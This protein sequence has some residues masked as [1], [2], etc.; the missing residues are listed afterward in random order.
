MLRIWS[1]L[2]GLDPKLERPSKRYGSVPTDG[3]AE[4][5]NIMPHWDGMLREYRRTLGW[6]EEHGIPT[7]E[8]LRELE[9]A[10]MIPV[11]ERIRAERQGV[12]A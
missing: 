7:D 4:G 12:P 6:D 3:P 1:F 10:E 11:V 2:H 5:A 9:L 8:T